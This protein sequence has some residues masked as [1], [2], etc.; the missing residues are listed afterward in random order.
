MAILLLSMF[1]WSFDVSSYFVLLFHP[2]WITNTI[3]SFPQTPRL[4]E[5]VEWKTE[6]ILIRGE[7]FLQIPFS[8]DKHHSLDSDAAV[9]S[10]LS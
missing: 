10:R 9:L 7:L 3:V 8:H 6:I 1:S 5:T 4:Q 2:C